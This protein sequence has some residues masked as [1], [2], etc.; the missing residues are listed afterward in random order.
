MARLTDRSDMII[1][2]YHG[3][4]TTTQLNNVS[5]MISCPGT[6]VFAKPYRTGQSLRSSTCLH[7]FM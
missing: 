1:D 6:L 3:R 2:V 4:K 7:I 5:I